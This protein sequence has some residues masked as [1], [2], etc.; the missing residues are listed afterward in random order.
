M[1]QTMLMLLQRYSNLFLEGVRYTLFLAFITVAVGTIIGTV[2]A[3]GKMCRFKLISFLATA[4]IE[5][6]RGTPLLLQLYLF[7]FLVPQL[8]PWEPS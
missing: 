3:L 2:L 1:I 4:Y 8:L 7:Y 6:I 5:I